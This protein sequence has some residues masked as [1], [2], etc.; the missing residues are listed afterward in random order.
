M[1]GLGGTELLIV[2]GIF[3]L[4]FG[5]SQIPKLAHALGKGKSELQRGLADGMKEA[6]M[7]QS[8]SKP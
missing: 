6:E 7:E 5:S 1:F 8:T 4:L 2:L 3:I